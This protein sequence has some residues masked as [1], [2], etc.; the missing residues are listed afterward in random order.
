MI[1][2]Q[3]KFYFYNEKRLYLAK[4]FVEGAS[5]NCLKILK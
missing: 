5:K 2:N 1:I 4:K 3:A